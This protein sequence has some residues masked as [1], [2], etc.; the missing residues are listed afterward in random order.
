MLKRFVNYQK[1]LAGPVVV[2]TCAVFFM[3]SVGLAKD[4]G[5]KKEMSPT[6]LYQAVD[7][8]VGYLAKDF[9]EISTVTKKLV[10]MNY[11]QSVE[12]PDTLKSYMVKKLEQ[13]AKDNDDTSVRMIQCV[14]CLA[15]QAE[16]V[17]DEIFI[18]K[19]VPNKDDLKKLLARHEA[20]N[21][22]DINV[23]YA[24]KQ[25]VLQMSIVDVDG[26]VQWSEEYRT[27]LNAYEESQWLIGAAYQVVSYSGKDMPNP[28]AGRIYVGQKLYGVGAAGIDVSLYNKT[29]ELIG[30]KTYSA[31]FELN[32]NEFF[33]AYWNYVQLSYMVL[34]GVTDFNA[35]QQ[36]AEGLGAK[37]KLG[38]YFVFSLSMHANQFMSKPKDDTDINNPKGKPF[39]KNNDPLPSRVILGIGVEL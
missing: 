7:V 16:A 21:Y 11:N 23:V 9:P 8:V 32:H 1:L 30:A 29:P 14:E 36:I 34:L 6:S 31:F 17:G 5:K 18:K 28:Q 26:I 22:A 38:D 3:S 24:G 20:R 15:I 37:V 25:L 13:T 33:Q 12:F 27:I 10:I 19:G 35:K 2:A 4:T 39:L